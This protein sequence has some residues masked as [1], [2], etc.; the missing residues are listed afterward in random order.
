MMQQFM[1]PKNK[2]VRKVQIFHFLFSGWVGLKGLRFY[3]G[4]GDLMLE[5]GQFEYE[6]KEVTLQEDERIVGVTAFV[7]KTSP[8]FYY[9][10][11][12]LICCLK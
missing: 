5:V 8:A 7:D 12:F 1:L 3:D 2:N 6:M 4:R 9:D 11:Q 10:L